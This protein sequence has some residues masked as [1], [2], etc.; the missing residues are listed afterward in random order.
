MPERVVVDSGP[1]I[2]LFNRDDEYHEQALQ[3]VRDSSAELLSTMAVVTEVMYVLDFSLRAQT[4][5]LTWLRAGAMTLVEPHYDDFDRVKQLMEKYAD[6]PMDFV[7]GVLVA[8]CE[9]LDIRNVASVDED[10]SIYR[11]KGR[12]R[13]T[14]VFFPGE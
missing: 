4:D 8:I 9:R 5:F 3:F 11:F 6:R 13:F 1:C 7:D 14:N 12:G 2:A 10:F